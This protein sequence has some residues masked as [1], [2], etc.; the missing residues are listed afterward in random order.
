MTTAKGIHLRNISKSYGAVTALDNVCLDVRE[1]EFVTLLGPSGS[2]KTTLLMVVAG[3]TSPEAGSVNIGER[4]VT[5]LAPFRR[6]IGVVFQNYALFPH[7]SVQQNIE[8]PLRMRHVPRAERARKAAQAIATVRLEGLA[9]RM[10]GQLSGGQKQRVA[11]ARAMV[12]NPPVLLMDEPLSAL[13]KNLREHMQLELKDLQ[14]RLGITVLY[15]THDQQ[16]ALTMSDRIAVINE[17]RVEQFGPAARI[18]DT[19]ANRFVA[20]FIGETNLFRATTLEAGN[21]TLAVSLHDGA[22]T[23]VR[24]SCPLCSGQQGYLSIR[25][26]K[27]AVVNGNAASLC[28]LSGRLENLIHQGDTIKYFIRPQGLDSAGSTGLVVMKMHNRA[29]TPLFAPGDNINFG[30]RPDDATFV[31]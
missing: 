15:V 11:L 4:N 10:P 26:E 14:Q 17:G 6:D 18:Y 24:T 29:D 25:P 2:G 30:W 28:A 12:F 1:K 31:V 8:Y 20:E 22:N 9:D 16:E 13:D 5:R 19:P 7:M 3:F 21:S 23:A 27:L